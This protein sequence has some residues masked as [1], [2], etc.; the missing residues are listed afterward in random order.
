MAALQTVFYLSLLSKIE[1]VTF[2]N[3]LHCHTAQKQIKSSEDRKTF[4]SYMAMI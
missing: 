2:P 3:K 1:T 4:Q